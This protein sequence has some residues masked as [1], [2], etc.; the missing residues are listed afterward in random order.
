M[1]N[2][3][4]PCSRGK[5][6]QMNGGYSNSKKGNK[7]RHGLFGSLGFQPQRV[8]CWDFNSL[9]LTV[10]VNVFLLHHL[11]ALGIATFKWKLH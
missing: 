8:V 6:S 7:S 2:S 3:M 9:S 10:R 4:Q 1:I 11:E 5:L